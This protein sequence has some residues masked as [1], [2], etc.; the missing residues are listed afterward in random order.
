MYKE[1]LVLVEECT[2]IPSLRLREFEAGR[3]R[4]IWKRYNVSW[5]FYKRGSRG[6]QEKKWNNCDKKPLGREKEK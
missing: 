2:D 1:S 3:R 4:C 5:C 6:E